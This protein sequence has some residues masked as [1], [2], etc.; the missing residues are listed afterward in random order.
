MCLARAGPTR[1]LRRQKLKTSRKQRSHVGRARREMKKHE[2]KLVENTKTLLCMKGLSCSQIVTDMLKDLVRCLSVTCG[3]TR[4]GVADCRSGLCCTP[5]ATFAHR[6]LLLPAVLLCR[7]MFPA[8]H[9]LRTTDCFAKA[10][11]PHAVAAEPSGAVRGRH[12]P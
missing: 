5:F 7:L 4:A 12:V 2:P 6:M 10:A 3:R 8:P 11:G 1:S 9:R